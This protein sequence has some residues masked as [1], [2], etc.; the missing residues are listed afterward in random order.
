[1][2]AA[3]FQTSQNR[4]GQAGR[5]PELFYFCIRDVYGYY[6]NALSFDVIERP[7][8]LL[9]CFQ[10]CSYGEDCRVQKQEEEGDNAGLEMFAFQ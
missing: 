9:A 5:L 4:K 8:L 3:H 7:P 10:V 1:M 6:G 2:V